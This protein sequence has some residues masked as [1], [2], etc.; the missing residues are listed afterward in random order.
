MC[1]L[2]FLAKLRCFYRVYKLEIMIPFIRIS[3]MNGVSKTVVHNAPEGVTEIS[4]SMWLFR[5]P[6]FLSFLLHLIKTSKHV[7]IKYA[8]NHFNSTFG[9]A[10]LNSKNTKLKLAKQV[11]K[12]TRKAN[13]PWDL[14]LL[15]GQ[16]MKYALIARF[17]LF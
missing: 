4:A 10:Y 5:S 3:G 9:S 16:P 12:E 14:G 8:P 1:Y 6:R 17:N 13:F 15:F 2:G 7:R 11:K